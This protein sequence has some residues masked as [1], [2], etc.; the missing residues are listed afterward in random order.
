MRALDDLDSTANDTVAILHF[1]HHAS[2]VLFDHHDAPA[3][4][5]AVD[6]AA[7]DC[8][9]ADRIA[10]QRHDIYVVQ[11][12]LTD[13]D[14]AALIKESEA[15]AWTRPIVLSAQLSP[16]SKALILDTCLFFAIPLDALTP[17]MLRVIVGA[18]KRCRREEEARR[19][20][21]HRLRASFEQLPNATYVWQATQD[22][23]FV[24]VHAN[25][26]AHAL[27]RQRIASSMGARARE[28]FSHRP[29]IFD[30]MRECFR[31]RRP[32]RTEGPYLM[33]TTGEE[34]YLITTSAF[35]APDVVVSHTVDE[36]A[37]RHAQTELYERER[38]FRALFSGA[39]DAMLVVD[40]GSRMVD[41][42]PALLALLGVTHESLGSLGLSQVVDSGEFT[43][44][45]WHA[46][47]TQGSWEG[48]F[49]VK[50][51]DDK[52]R[53][54]DFSA[55]ADFTPGRHLFVLRDVTD[56]EEL[57]RDLQHALRLDSVGRLAGG[58]AHD[59]NN[60]LTAILGFTDL[61]SNTMPSSDP[62]RADLREITRAAESA[63]GLTRQLLAFSRKQVL[64][65]VVLDINEQV[66]NVGALLRRLLGE[67]VEV[68]TAFQTAQLHVT[69]DP[70]QI[71]QI[72]LN[73]A[74]NARDAM[75]GTGVLRISTDR[76]RVAS[77][78][79]REGTKVTPGGYAVLSIADTGQGM[80]EDVLA[81]LFEPFYTTKS[82]GSGTGLGLS[83]VY[84]IVKQ[85]G[86]YIWVASEVGR[87]T[88][89]DIW[90][91]LATS[92]AD[93]T[94]E[95]ATRSAGVMPDVTVLIVDDDRAVR[96]LAARSLELEGCRVV[97]AANPHEARARINEDV[98][99][100]ITDVVMPANS[101]VELARELREAYP[102]LRVLFISG[103]AKEAIRSYGE[104]P[105]GFEFL[106][107]PF[108]PD[109]LVL[110]ALHALGRSAPSSPSQSAS[111]D[112]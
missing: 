71:E 64:Q 106:G 102:S 80:T 37:R 20:A 36:T 95:P 21:E 11:R 73:L 112:A 23:D 91:P 86:G 22:D 61:L 99:L 7:A 72:L 84:G 32:V 79:V 82:R 57:E 5:V 100:L 12:A 69:A 90:L 46:F 6:A 88:T 49:R 59:F 103:Y 77:D 50:R 24:L 66:T 52:V 10:E 48:R 75:Q 111:R 33:R 94:P 56:R 13:A 30:A 93:A 109:A 34:R 3:T 31:L 60:L 85:T 110:K 42:N 18:A 105:A 35:V 78:L 25:E 15:G 98:Q 58:I 68:E 47:L 74:I 14:V 38:Q 96:A 97:E 53:T 29:D 108:K 8:A 62:R 76:L 16:R 17:D 9:L 19:T 92:G 1:T 55:T 2:S 81:H 83:T 4:A 27:T 45:M 28:F 87:G 65:P 40:D 43:D 54:V 26:A 107:K 41:G 89:F 44:E 67:D 39:K 63:A 70:T 101:G 104:L 51:A